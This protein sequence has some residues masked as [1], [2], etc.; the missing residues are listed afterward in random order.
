M[1]GHLRREGRGSVY[2]IMYI[3]I[4]LAHNPYLYWQVILL[5][6]CRYV[7]CILYTV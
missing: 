6:Y 7:Q 2:I 3:I 5:T 1:G 4:I